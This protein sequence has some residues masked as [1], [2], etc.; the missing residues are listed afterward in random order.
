MIG[1]AERQAQKLAM[2]LIRSGCHVEVLT[3]RL[4]K[5]WPLED[6]IDGLRINRFPFINLTH[7]LKGVRGLGVP[8]TLFL[9]LSHILWWQIPSNG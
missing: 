7:N 1:G 5:S 8:N 2:A 6:T 9:G 4:E 3:P